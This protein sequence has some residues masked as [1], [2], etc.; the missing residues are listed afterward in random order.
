[1]KGAGDPEKFE[2]LIRNVEKGFVSHY[3]SKGSSRTAMTR[4]VVLV[5]PSGIMEHGK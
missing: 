1:M 3:G 5:D 4:V 2:I